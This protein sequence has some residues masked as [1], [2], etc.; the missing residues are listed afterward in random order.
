MKIDWKQ[1]AASEGY[2]SLKKCYID[3]EVSGRTFSNKKQL[4]A[5]FQWVLNRAKYY[6]Y[7]LGVS[8]ETVLNDWEEKRDYWWMNYYQDCRQPKFNN[9]SLKPIGINGIKK[10]IKKDSWF[11]D[12]DKKHRMCRQIQLFQADAST[13]KK[14]RW[15]KHT[16]KTNLSSYNNHI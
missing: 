10:N 14:A 3:D 15:S 13:K 12:I 6:S 4:Y 2:I 1:L 5:K 16:T 11:S 7:W 8:M 9:N